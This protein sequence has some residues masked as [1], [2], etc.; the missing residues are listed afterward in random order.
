MLKESLLST[1]PEIS[2]ERAILITESY[3]ETE[4][5]PMVIRRA[6]A[7]DK[8][9]RNMSIYILPGELIVGGIAHKQRAAPVFPEY[10][11]EYLEK[12]LNEFEKRPG[13][14]FKISEDDK[15]K[16]KEILPY[17]KGKTVKERV[18]S[19]CPKETLMAGEGGL[20]YQ[21]VGVAD[22]TWEVEN[23]DGHIIAGYDKLL[24]VGLN[25][26]LKEAKESLDNLDLSEPQNIPKY[27]FLKAVIIALEA[28]M[29]Y[30]R[31]YSR[32]AREM[33]Q[34]T[35]DPKQKEELEKIAEICEWVPANPAR[36]FH[37]AIQSVWFAHCI[38]QIETNGHS[39]SLG[40]FDQYMYSYF[41]K[42]LKAGRLTRQE[43]LE[44]V[45]CLYVKLSS[46]N[47]LRSWDGTRFLAGYPMFQN[48]T[49]GGQTRDG[50]DATNELS[51]ICLEAMANLRLHQP[52]LS[53]RIHRRTP[54]KFLRKCVDV[55]KIGIG[56]PALFNDDVIIPAML[57]N[58]KVHI[59]DA[60][61][62]GLVGC[63]E[64][65]V[66]GKWGGRHAGCLF[67]LVK[68]M[69]LALYNGK[70]PRTGI[71]LCPGDG[72]LTTFTSLEDLLNAFEKQVRYYVKQA[73]IKDNIIDL[74]YE[75][76]TPTPFLS[77]LIEDCIK[78]GKDIKQG[79]AIYDCTAISTGGIANIANSFAAIAK[80]VFEDKLIT[81]SQLKHA[82]ETNFEDRS[83]DPTGEQIRRMLRNA[84]KYGN[85]DPYVDLIAKEV[86]RIFM[87]EVPKYKTTRY[88][89]GP[90]GCVFLPDWASVSANIPWG[91]VIGATPD[92]R[93]A[94]EPV[95][96]VE[97]ADMGTDVSGPTA[98]IKSVANIDHIL[99]SDGAI[100]NLR[101]SPS[102]FEN[103]DKVRKFIA[104]IKTYF[105][106]EGMEMQFN[107]IS[108]KTLRDA[109]K[110]PEKYRDLMVRVAG[111]TA[112][113][114][115]LDKAVQDAIIARTEH[116]VK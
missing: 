75:E 35:R 113:F 55:I 10:D 42:D 54:E 20:G 87:A 66:M 17:W 67:N 84:P 48:L 59:E 32:L 71:T 22:S 26:I 53:A 3:R 92:G 24:R 85:D 94:G 30:A 36:T 41:E 110:H 116:V 105:D 79:G 21:G 80:V 68:C 13:D 27:H 4:S 101:F 76:L 89:R 50:R 9:L 73:A 11:V 95:A 15:K 83:T 19:M 98:L 37:E 88:R 114:V 7:L 38:I 34:E 104:L 74:M 51:Y 108:T 2:V 8:I 61:D 64:P 43:A 29:E 28:A 65:S 90:I 102:V 1:T 69:E 57:H 103:E 31:R 91:F 86:A 99:L 39:V 106:L 18:Y 111:Y 23:G 25:G 107:V 78:R 40:R 100:F 82:L 33:A 81:T 46:I 56:F 109:Q 52:S 70:D 96:D 63:V 45:E 60:F 12:E 16:L 112:P 97:S 93:K 47:K 44:L 58:A 6:K 72:D 49:V 5:E 62:Y 77:A 115:S 14:A